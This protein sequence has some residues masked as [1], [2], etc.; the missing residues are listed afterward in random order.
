M[1][2]KARKKQMIRCLALCPFLL[3][4]CLLFTGCSPK[5]EKA[6]IAPT[7]FSDKTADLDTNEK[8]NS[9]H[10]DKATV[11]TMR[12]AALEGMSPESIKRLKTVISNANLRLERHLIFED[13]Q[14]HLSNPDDG[15]WK[16]LDVTGEFIIGYAYK[17]EDMDKKEQLGLTEE[18]FQ[19]KYGEPVYATSDYDAK[20]ILQILGELEES[21]YNESFRK[22]FEALSDLVQKAKDTHDVNCVINIYRI[23][24]DMDYYLLRYGPEDVGKYMQDKTTLLKYY[25]VL[26]DYRNTNYYNEDGFL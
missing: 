10:P 22:N 23:L 24:H 3:V 20:A 11:L 2:K 16:Y 9:G 14:D 21:V 26:E 12:S 17:S 19:K 13:L 5:T 8:R 18:E 6:S 15:T 1:F 25:G 4:L 7:A